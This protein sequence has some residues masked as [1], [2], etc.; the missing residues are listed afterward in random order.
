[1]LKEGG[2]NGVSFG[3]ESFEEDLVK[4]MGG[5]DEKK[6]VVTWFE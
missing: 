1:M 4:K 5:V 2:V 6:D 3:V